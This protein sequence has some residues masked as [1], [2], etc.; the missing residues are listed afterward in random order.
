MKKIKLLKMMMMKK[1]K[2]IKMMRIRLRVMMRVC[3]KQ[4]FLCA[5]LLMF[6]IITRNSANIYRILSGHLSTCAGIT[7][8]M[9]CPV[10]NLVAKLSPSGHFQSTLPVISLNIIVK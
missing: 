2:L 8:L 7:F 1:I 9:D 4:Q 3:A 5:S 6:L 10:C